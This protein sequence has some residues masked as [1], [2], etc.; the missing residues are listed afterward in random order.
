MLSELIVGIASWI[1]GSIE[2]LTTAV[3]LVF[4]AHYLRK[5]SMVGAVLNNLGYF[6]AF[7][8]LLVV[9]GVVDI[10]PSALVGFVETAVRALAGVMP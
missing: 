8:A 9:T 3:M 6:G 2:G 1:F 4:G 5:A 7:L 10:H